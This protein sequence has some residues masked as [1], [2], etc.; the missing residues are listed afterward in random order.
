MDYKLEIHKLIDNIS[1]EHVLRF[2]YTFIRYL[3]NN[4]DVMSVIGKP[5]D[6]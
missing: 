4:E 3:V 2:L 6:G 5:P 1:Q